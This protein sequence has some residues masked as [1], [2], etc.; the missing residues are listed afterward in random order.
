MTDH[1]IRILCVDDHR[2]VREGLAHIINGQPD[3]TVVASVASGKEAVAEFARCH[4][5]V[6]LM[7]LQLGGMDGVEAIHL[8]RDNDRAARIVVLTM[9]QGDEDIYRALQAGAATYLT[10]DTL[11]D[12]LIR[13]IREVHSGK[14]PEIDPLM[15]E[16]LAERARGPTL[17]ARETQVL[18]LIAHGMRNKEIAASLGISEETAQVHVKH[19]LA[20]LNVHDRTLA[21]IVGLRRGVIHVA[22]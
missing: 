15:G 18:G 3:M 2:I 19:I 11:G 20:K 13:V 8:I 12:N 14:Q 21:I 6:T 17:T 9:Y 10:K 5:D 4:P 22:T 16:L 1:K 7:D